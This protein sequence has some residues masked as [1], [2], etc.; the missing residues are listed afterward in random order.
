MWS[1]YELVT[2][3][4]PEEIA[5]LKNSVAGGSTHP[6][7]V[8]MQLAQEVVTGFHGEAAGRK[9][10]ESF[11][12]VFR[13]RKAPEEAPVK[14]LP[15][16][17]PQAIKALLMTLGLAASMSDAERLVKQGAVE[18]DDERIDDPRK[19]IDLSHPRDF[20]IRA[21]KKK[22]VRVVVS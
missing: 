20:R 4:K 2:D 7:D 16:G 11:Q 12:H 1:Y 6:M 15:V 8:K 22:F 10:A 19:P 14:N 21:G 18:I 13:D 9:A 5:D 3:R 17:A